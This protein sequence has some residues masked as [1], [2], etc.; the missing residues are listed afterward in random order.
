MLLSNA[1]SPRDEVVVPLVDPGLRAA[2]PAEGVGDFGMI[3]SSPGFRAAV[4]LARK[5]ADTDASVLILGESGVGKELLSHMVHGLSR[6]ARGPFVALNCAALPES[7]A[8]AELF[9]VNKGA[10]TGAI[11]SR[12]GRFERAHRG[13]LFL[14]EIGT[15]NSAAQAKLLRVLQDGEVERVGDTG[16]RL[17]DVRIIAATNVDLEEAVKRGQFR[18]DLYYRL[19]VFP[20]VMPPLR[21]RR[22]DIPA[23][24]DHFMRRASQ[25]QGK[26]LMGID[27]ALIDAACHHDW[28]GNIRELQNMVERAV[29]LAEPGQ[30]LGLRHFSNLAQAVVHGQPPAAVGAPGLPSLEEA[31]VRLL[32]LALDEAGGNLSAAARLLKTSR[33]TLAYRLRKHGI[34]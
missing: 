30:V 32:R 11:L 14:D 16:S 15:L 20:I 8:E 2:P 19:N 22:E 26:R 13:T 34:I 28:P 29:I 21:E 3:G 6:R 24:L 4:S 33:Q 1:V 10:Y 7:L 12:P 17:V 9:G 5:V 25:K 31:E 18:A 27:P 23:L